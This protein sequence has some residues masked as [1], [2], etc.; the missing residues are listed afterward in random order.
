[1]FYPRC[2]TN[3]L[4][5]SGVVTLSA[6]SGGTSTPSASPTPQESALEAPE[7][8]AAET[9]E[10]EITVDLD[11]SALLQSEIQ[12]GLFNDGSV[13][14]MQ[15]TMQV[16]NLATNEIEI[17]PWTANVD[18]TDLNNIQSFQTLV[19]EPGDYLLELALSQGIHSYSGSALHNVSDGDTETADMTIRPVIG[20]TLFDV[21][22]I[23]ELID[24]RFSFSAAEIN[25]A[26]L[27]APSVGIS[28]NGGN[29]QIFLLNTTTGLTEHMLL[30]LVPGQ[31]DISLRLL[32]N[33]I[34]VGKSIAAQESSVTVA[35]GL[36]VSLDVIPLHGEFAMDLTAEGGDATIDLRFPVEVVEEVGGISNLDAI[37]RVAGPDYP[38]YETPLAATA[39]AQGYGT[40]VV[41]PNVFFGEM[42]FEM[43]F[44]DKTDN[45]EIGYCI[46]TTDLSSTSASLTCDMTLR[47][48]QVASGSLLSTLGINVRGL[49]GVPVAGA[50]ISIAGEEVAITNSAAFSTPGYSKVF[51]PSGT[52]S[53]KAQF[54]VA[55]GEIEFVSQPLTVSNVDIVLNTI[56]TDGDGIEDN[57]DACPD[58][59]ATTATGC[60][61]LDTVSDL[62]I[63]TFDTSDRVAVLLSNGTEEPTLIEQN[64]TGGNQQFVETADVNGDGLDDAIVLD[65]NTGIVRVAYAPFT[66]NGVQLVV[67]ADKSDAPGRDI[68]AADV[69]N[70]DV[71]DLLIPGNAEHAVFLGNG[72]GSFGPELPFAAA[73]IDNR[74]L[75][76]A[77]FDGDGNIDVTFSSNA[78]AGATPIHFGNGTGDFSNAEVVTYPNTGTFHVRAGDADGDGDTDIL[79]AGYTY[80]LRVITNNG[81]RTPPVGNAQFASERFLFAYDYNDD[82]ADDIMMTNDTTLGLFIRLNDGTGNFGD[83]TLIGDLPGVVTRGVPLDFNADGNMDIA[84][85]SHVGTDVTVVYGNGDGT[86]GSQESFVSVS[87]SNDLASGRFD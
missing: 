75:A 83:A 38:L 45:S 17:F 43:T 51:I 80:G 29:E 11:Y 37:F 50:V 67:V 1:M 19:L 53:I 60:P 15:G 63:G 36:D 56:D 40:S 7:I 57:L 76:V 34:Q 87:S 52:H 79:M 35:Q 48:R 23:A 4:I 61:I 24:F 84:V 6:C 64:V 71:F 8:A 73:T 86:F 49:D 20:Q 14:L 30:N 77:D 25:T 54:G 10:R 66:P 32:D 55:S 12:P 78:G 5:L 16:T 3:A 31:Y 33:G 41:L 82:G 27:T 47:R 65:Q 74:S 26:N 81:S 22:T 21:N 62:L 59:P 58:E 68:I 13:N 69:N 46:T 85:V 42:T 9:E 39:I 70:D 72:D 2:I 18:P 44:S 28:I